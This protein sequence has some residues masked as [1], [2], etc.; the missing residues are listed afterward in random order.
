MP[1]IIPRTFGAIVAE[2]VA[3]N[4]ALSLGF[5]WDGKIREKISGGRPEGMAVDSHGTIYGGETTS[6]HDLKVFARP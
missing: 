1:H 5:W 3:P 4:R 2:F 6:G